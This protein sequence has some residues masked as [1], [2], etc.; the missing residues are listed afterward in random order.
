M[1][2]KENRM[3]EER[4]IFYFSIPEFRQRERKRINLCRYIASPHCLTAFIHLTSMD[5]DTW[6]RQQTLSTGI[7]FPHIL[8]CKRSVNLL[9]FMQTANCMA[10]IIDFTL[11]TVAECWTKIIMARMITSGREGGGK[12]TSC[13]P[14]S[15][16]TW[17]ERG[18]LLSRLPLVS[19]S[20]SPCSEL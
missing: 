1:K 20:V 19:K 3:G 2:W 10:K 15:S 12:C 17:V 5:S 8:I 7:F 13:A 14:L 6:E 4:W 16:R 18:S 9:R 11:N